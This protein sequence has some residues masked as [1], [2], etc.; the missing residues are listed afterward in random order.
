MRHGVPLRDNRHKLTRQRLG[1]PLASRCHHSTPKEMRINRK[2]QACLPSHTIADCRAPNFFGKPSAMKR[3]FDC[4]GEKKCAKRRFLDLKN[5]RS[6]SCA[7]GAYSPYVRMA[8]ERDRRFLWLKSDG[9]SPTLAKPR[10]HKPTIHAFRDRVLPK[11]HENFLPVRPE[12]IKSLTRPRRG[13]TRT[14]NTKM[15]PTKTNETK[16]GIQQTS[17]YTKHNYKRQGTERRLTTTNK[18][19]RKAYSQPPKPERSE[20]HKIE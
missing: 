8:H 14:S 4:R 1:K 10:A 5:R 7:S 11:L 2:S 13:C 16:A 6:R 17:N 19:R 9:S 20:W 3:S 12:P 15:H 18:E